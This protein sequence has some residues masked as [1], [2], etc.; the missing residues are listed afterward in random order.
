M[1]ATLLV[2]I[3]LWAGQATVH[4]A[5]V[6]KCSTRAGDWIGQMTI[7]EIGESQIEI[8]NS[9]SKIRVNC[10]LAVSKF[11]NRKTSMEPSV[12]I[13]L[14]SDEC[15]GRPPQ[16]LDQLNLVLDWS[17]VKPTGARL[18]WLRTEQPS[19]CTIEKAD[20]QQ[21]DVLIRRFEQGTLK[22]TRKPRL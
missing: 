20:A 1:I 21:L 19:A 2:T 7:S 12:L 9:K 22:G 17:G 3:G 10:K 6:F 5:E 15:L 16:L 13:D 18:Y 14:E 8:K 4:A 11:A